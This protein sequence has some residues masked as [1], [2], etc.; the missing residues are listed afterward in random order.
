VGATD[1]R[2]ILGRISGV[3][4]IKGWVKVWSFTDPVDGLLDYPVWQLKLP[5]GWEPREVL[6]S[7]RQGKGLIAHLAGCADRDQA[8]RLVQAEIAVPRSALPRLPDGEYYWQDLE[9]LRVVAR[10]ADGTRCWLGVVDHLI[11]T[12][13]NDVLVVRPAEGSVDGRERLVPWV[14][15]KVVLGVDLAAGEIL[16]D[17]DPD[18]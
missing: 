4:G 2:V 12:G 18:F 17:W 8:L 14:E 11:A 6:A 15:D 3:F 5:G 1:D 9:G 13:A 16:V 10:Q 7:Q